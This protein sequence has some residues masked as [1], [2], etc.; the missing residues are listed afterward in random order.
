MRRGAE[1]RSAALRQALKQAGPTGRL[2][3]QTQAA[4]AQLPG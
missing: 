2:L 1:P 3:D 4:L